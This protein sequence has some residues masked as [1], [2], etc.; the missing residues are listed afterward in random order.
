MGGGEETKGLTAAQP[1]HQF[2]LNPGSFSAASMQD[3]QFSPTRPIIVMREMLE[4]PYMGERMCEQ[5]T[6]R[7]CNKGGARDSR[8]GQTDREDSKVDRER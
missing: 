6:R 3:E 5:E 7:V 2:P 8:E 1:R 4:R